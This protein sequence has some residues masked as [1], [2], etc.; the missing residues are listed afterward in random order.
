MVTRN[1]VK[2]WL[3][4]PAAVDDHYRRVDKLVAA[5]DERV[6]QQRKWCKDGR[7]AGLQWIHSLQQCERHLK[8]KVG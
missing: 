2:A 7:S 6:V 5:G 4:D 3:E 8:S 1:E